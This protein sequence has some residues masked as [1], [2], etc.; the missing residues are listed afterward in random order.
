MIISFEGIC[1]DIQDGLFEL[2]PQLTIPPDES[3][4]YIILEKSNHSLNIRPSHLFTSA[5]SGAS[6][7]VSQKLTKRSGHMSE[8]I[9]KLKILIEQKSTNDSWIW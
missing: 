9:F 8:G 3:I 1:T 6:N 7:I 4:N 2:Q 5:N